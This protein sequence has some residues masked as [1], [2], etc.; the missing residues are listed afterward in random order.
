[1]SGDSGCESFAKILDRCDNLRDIRYSG[2][3]ASERGSALFL[4]AM[5]TLASSSDKLQNLRRLDL[6]DNTF[7]NCGLSLA[8]TLTSC[9]NLEYLSVKDC[10]L[11]D[12]GVRSV[13]SSLIESGCPLTHLD[14]SGNEITQD[15]I[16]DVMALLQND[17]IGDLIQHLVMEDCEMTST[18][19]RRIASLL[20][21]T[22][23]GSNLQEIN[24]EGNECGR[25]GAV[26]LLD[27]A[28]TGVLP[29][30]KCIR[31]D[32]NMFPSESVDAL[33]T[34]FGTKLV[35]MEDNDDDDDVDEDMDDE[36]END[37]EIVDDLAYMLG[38][39]SV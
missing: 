3:R 39:V 6:A 35:T 12:A 13:C 26:A 4:K 37:D 18:G 5:E 36:E 20:K 2:T 30:L 27:L 16:K 24:F 25:I 19:V 15:T 21:S 11:D 23:V 38:K 29:N 31:L 1:M 17:V 10:I 14:L 7:G 22:K 32:R 34:A 8:K 33:V 9:S 28:V